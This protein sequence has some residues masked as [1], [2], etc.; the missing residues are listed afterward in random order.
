[1]GRRQRGGHAVITFGTFGLQPHAYSEIV[2]V[3]MS[4]TATP[5]CVILLTCSILCPV[6]LDQKKKLDNEESRTEESPHL[7][8]SVLSQQHGSDNEDGPSVPVREPLV[9]YY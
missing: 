4:F 7:V 2:T 1:M 9:P 6:L 5:T 3:V 8:E